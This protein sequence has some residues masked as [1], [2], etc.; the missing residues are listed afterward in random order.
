MIRIFY[1]GW[2]NSEEIGALGW[3]V[4]FIIWTIITTA[5]VGYVGSN[6]LYF[7]SPLYGEKL[8]FTQNAL[9]YTNAL[10]CIG[11]WTWFVGQNQRGVFDQEKAPKLV[12]KSKTQ[13]ALDFLTSTGGR[14]G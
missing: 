13:E 4:L 7:W 8:A 5:F 11:R 9:S 14:R 12:V 10:F 1:R 6:I 2:D 3:L